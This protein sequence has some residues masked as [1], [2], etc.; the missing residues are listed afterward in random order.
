VI[1]LTLGALKGPG[2]ALLGVNA[3]ALLFDAQSSCVVVVGADCAFGVELA[4]LFF[5]DL[6]FC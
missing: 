4:L 5:A 2:V 3:A 6:C 1:S